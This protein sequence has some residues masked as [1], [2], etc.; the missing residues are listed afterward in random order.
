[1][2]LLLLLTWPYV[3]KHRLRSLLTLAGIVLGVAVFVGMHTANLN[4]GRAFTRTVDQIAGAAQLQVSAGETGFPEE[5]LERVQSVAD[6][7]AAAPVIEAALNTGLPGQGNLLVLGVDMTGDGSLR[8][9]DLEEEDVIDDPLIF[10]AQ[11]DSLILSKQFAERN[12][13]VRNAKITLNTMQGQK[14]FTVRGIMKAGGLASAFGGNLAVMD[15][16]AAQLVFGRGR[17]FDRIDIGVK[18][19]V[20]V[21]E[22]R[23]KLE[24]LL[25]PGFQVEPP[26]S[27]AQH[28]E[29]VSK[30]LSVTI[31][32]TSVFALLIGV[33]IIYNSFAIAITERRSEIG[34]L[35]ALGASQNKVL[36][37]FIAESALAGLVGSAV[38][39]W[40]GLLLARGITPQLSY[41]VQEV[42]GTPQAPEQSMGDPGMILLA[43]A[44]GLAAS[45]AG[46]ILPARAAAQVDPVKALQKGRYQVIGVGE[47]RLRRIFALLFAGSATACLLLGR[48][49]TAFYAG[50]VQV[51]ASLL[52]LSPALAVWLAHA[53]RPLFRWIRPVEGALAANSLIQSPRRT[54]ATVSALMLSLALA[55]GFAG[56]SGAIYKSVLDWMDSA[57]N[58]DLFVWPSENITARNFRFPGSFEQELQQVPGVEDVQCVRN[59]RVIVKGAP[60]MA[61]AIPI[62]RVS[63]RVALSPVEGSAE[64]MNRLSAQGKG[65]ILADNLAQM[66]NIHRGDVLELDSPSGRVRLPVLGT[67]IDYSDQQG[68]FLIDRSL[69]Q[70]LWQDDTFNGCRVHVSKS[71]SVDQ[72]KEAIQ[73]RFSQHRRLFVFTNHAI[74][75][76]VLDTTAAWFGLT[77]VQLAVALLV[78]ILGIVNTLTV[79]ISDRR[80]ELGVLQA[81]G[82]LRRQVRYTIWMEAVAIGLIGLVLGL[83]MGAITLYYNLEMLRRDIAGLRLPF[84]YPYL[85]ALALLPVIA[86]ASWIASLVPAES[87]VRASLVESLEY[88]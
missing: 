21:E 15:I 39:V 16:Y 70:K 46:G 23:R 65:V 24:Q 47:N 57:L 72:V 86:G 4:I 8:E 12:G 52:L 59:A 14:Q 3:R 26:S 51:I 19:G 48:S 50:Y 44:I 25:G 32:I 67:V 69:Y 13:I 43:M 85:F 37:L 40:L 38:G 74:R 73:A 54:S 61:V 34:I 76:Y 63:K 49:N 58:P 18:E 82:G 53:L 88:E 33:F 78:A 87:A 7:R 45:I 22:C 75:K 79:S 29:S 42:Y 35:R 17:M 60:A 66:R 28:F 11:P 56:V 36:G 6:V 81:V 80:R 55:V 84:A 77:Y 20:S 9:Y 10:L 83:A 62:E 5:V 27:R 41:L 71:A 68:S 64:E 31:N 2:K 30:G 1:M